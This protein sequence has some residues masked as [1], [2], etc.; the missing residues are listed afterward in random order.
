M[1]DAAEVVIISNHDH[2]MNMHP[3]MDSLDTLRICYFQSKFRT[4]L[5]NKGGFTLTF[6]LGPGRGSR[7]KVQDA[8][9]AFAEKAASGGKIQSLRISRPQGKAYETKMIFCPAALSILSPTE[10]P[11]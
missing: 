1:C 6:E 3:G 11:Q 4:S 10:V 9:L 7:G 8:L 2:T 5:L